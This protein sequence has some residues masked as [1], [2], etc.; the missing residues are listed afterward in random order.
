MQNR[1]ISA[2]ILLL[3]CYINLIQCHDFLIYYFNILSPK[4]C[5]SI[6]YLQHEVKVFICIKNM[7]PKGLHSEYFVL[8]V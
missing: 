3:K 5:V 1:Q 8:G 6:S 7:I 2:K 4:F